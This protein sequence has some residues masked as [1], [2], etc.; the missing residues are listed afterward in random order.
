MA[1]RHIGY[2]NGVCLSGLVVNRR[3]TER[4]VDLVEPVHHPFE[5][6]L[7]NELLET[8]DVE[9]E[10]KSFVRHE[11]CLHGS[12]AQFIAKNAGELREFPQGAVTTA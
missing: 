7:Q 6:F 12:Y 4:T 8:K 9:V 5:R 1:F 2:R 10:E 3:G 11:V